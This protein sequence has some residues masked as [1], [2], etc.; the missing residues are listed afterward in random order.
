MRRGQFIDNA[1]HPYDHHHH[2]GMDRNVANACG[3]AYEVLPQHPHASSADTAP[4]DNV[5]VR[6]LAA[7]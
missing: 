1:S 7:T 4:P 3:R 5:D 2:Q 6:G